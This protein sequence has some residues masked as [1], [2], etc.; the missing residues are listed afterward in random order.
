MT[1]GTAGSREASLEALEEDESGERDR[2][3]KFGSMKGVSDKKRK[4][5]L[6]MSRG[7][8]VFGTSEEMGDEPSAESCDVLVAIERVCF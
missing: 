1:R 6:G 7:R 4:F 2:L 3:M 5:G 8:R